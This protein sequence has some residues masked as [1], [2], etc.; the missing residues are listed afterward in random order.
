MA[1]ILKSGLC[2]MCPVRKW[3]LSEDNEFPYD[4]EFHSRGWHWCPR[5]D[6]Y[7]HDSMGC[8]DRAFDLKPKRI[9]LAVRLGLKPN[10][11]GEYLS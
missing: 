5:Q 2:K 6:D 8:N 1:L 3:A 11:Q 4:N 7:V 9:P 10:E